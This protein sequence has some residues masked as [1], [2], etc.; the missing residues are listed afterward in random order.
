RPR[1]S[2]RDGARSAPGGAGPRGPRPPP[3]HRRRPGPGGRG[4]P[5]RAAGRGG[6]VPAVGI[7]ATS[8]P[9]RRGCHGAT[10]APA[11]SAP[12][13]GGRRVS[14]MPEAEEMLRSAYRAF[15]ARKIETAVELMHPEVDWPNAWEG[16][17]MVGRAAVTE[18]WTR[19]FATISGQVEPERF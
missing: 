9:R 18:Y 6:C 17:R 16:G 15:N 4:E 14:R 10:D 1:R 19:Q 3:R 7:R 11:G 12:R 13:A 5:R 8:R 2:P